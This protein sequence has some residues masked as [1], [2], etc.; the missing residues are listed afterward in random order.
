M[1]PPE[2]SAVSRAL[3]RG[4]NWRFTASRWMYAA[5][6]PWRV[7]K[8]SASMRTTASK[9]ARARSRYGYARRTSA[10][11]ASSSHSAQ[12]TSA[13]ICCAS[14]SS[15]CGGITSASS[16]PRRTQSSRAVHSIRSSRVA[17]NSR[18]FGVPSM[19]WPERPARCR[20]AAIERGE[21]SWQ[22]R[23]TSP[24][25]MPSSSDAVAASTFSSPRLSRCSASSRSSLARLPW[26]AATCSLPSRSDRCRAARSAIRRVLTK[27]KVVRCACTSCARRS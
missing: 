18:A 17:G 19:L 15:G 14:T 8:P 20:N 27:T 7:V 12:A 5:R 3:R 22:T 9:S 21:P 23:S 26:C 25:S 2:V 1:V 4:R 11:S 16:S 13:T 24:M 10:Y 6:G